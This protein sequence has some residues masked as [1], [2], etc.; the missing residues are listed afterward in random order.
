MANFWGTGCSKFYKFLH[1]YDKTTANSFDILKR[2]RKSNE[3]DFMVVH[4]EFF[5]V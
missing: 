1:I 4:I 2:V 5:K 3:G